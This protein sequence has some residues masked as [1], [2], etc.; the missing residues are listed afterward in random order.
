MSTSTT[1]VAPTTT[2]TVAPTTTTTVA[3]TSTHMVTPE[4]TVI[5][6]TTA[7]SWTAQHV[8]DLLK[9]NALPGDFA[10][11]APKLT[12]KVQD[13]YPSQ[14][15]TSVSTVDGRYQ[16]FAAIMYLQGGSSTFSS[17]PDAVVGHEYGHVWTLYHLYLSQQG[18]W[19]SYLDARG[20]TGNASLDS[21]YAWTRQ[22]IIADDYR[23]LFGSAAAISERPTHLN[24][25]IPDPRNVA[26]LSSFLTSSWAVAKP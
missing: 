11:I 2:T 26:G 18:A 24:S 7:G 1:T 13:T 20:L 10:A 16:N 15:S 17:Q 9:Q 21:S 25:S 3:A 6:V 5:D 22:E 12:I 19:A 8:Y 4:G 23:L 14:T